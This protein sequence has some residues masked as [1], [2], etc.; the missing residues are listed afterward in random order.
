MAESVNV[1]FLKPLDRPQTPPLGPAPAQR[2]PK[3][4]ALRQLAPHHRQQHRPA[5]A[6]AAT[7]RRLGGDSGGVPLQTGIDLAGAARLPEHALAGVQ[8]AQQ[9]AALPPARGVVW[10]ELE[11]VERGAL[12]RMWGL[13]FGFQN[14]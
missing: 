6:D 12:K 7:A 2:V 3:V 8:L 4:D 1:S 5:A 14:G 9:A 10:G 11:S 13:P